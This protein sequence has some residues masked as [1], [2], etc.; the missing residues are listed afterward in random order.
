MASSPSPFSNNSGKLA[1]VSPWT[2]KTSSPSLVSQGTLV[3]AQSINNNFTI[4]NIGN[5]TQN[6]RPATHQN[7]TLLHQSNSSGMMST[8]TSIVRL[9]QPLSTPTQFVPQ[10]IWTTNGTPSSPRLQYASTVKQGE[11]RPCL[12]PSH[13]PFLSFLEPVNRIVGQNVVRQT[14]PSQPTS[15]FTES[16]IRDFVAKC[17]T[18]LITLLKLAEKQ[19]PE[20]LPMVRSCIQDLLNGT[21]DPESFT[22]RLHTLYKSQP[23][24]SLVPFFKVSVL[25]CMCSTPTIDSFS[26][27]CRTCVN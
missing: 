25:R 3:F 9:N 18:F 19:A 27:H 22:Q 7:G 14:A 4:N 24:T 5:A 17:R 6:I 1:P 10:T 12:Q 26:W 21:I 2:G 23:H 15:K 20:K 13:R 16:Q 11:I 8:P